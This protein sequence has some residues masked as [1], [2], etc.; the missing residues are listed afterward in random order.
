MF[1]EGG[2]MKYQNY[3]TEGYNLH[4]LK[5][6]N[7]KQIKIYVDLIT[8]EKQNFKYNIPLLASI[9]SR[10]NSKYK[11]IGDKYLASYELYAPSYKIGYQSSGTLQIFG[12]ALTF[13]NEKYTEKG[14]NEKTI[15]F[16]FNI[17]FNPKIKNDSFDEEI[18]EVIKKEDIHGMETIK[19]Q[20]R[21][22]ISRKL[23]ENMPV[24]RFPKLSLN[25]TI[26][27]EK[28]VTGKSLYKFYKNF[29]KN[30]RLEIFVTGDID[31]NQIKDIIQ[32]QITYKP[33]L[34][35]LPSPYITQ[36]KVEPLKIIKE[37]ISDKQSML[38]IGL[39]AQNLSFFESNYVLRMYSSIL[40]GDSS[41]LL[42]KEVREEKSLC[43]SITTGRDDFTGIIRISSAFDKNNY[44]EIMS[45]VKNKMEDMK[46]GNF[47]DT[48]I[49]DFK[50]SY[51]TSFDD[52]EDFI[53][54]CTNDMEGEI[55]Y[56][57]DS[58]KDKIKKIKKVTKED[59][60]NLAKKV[61]M[62]AIVFLEG[63]GQND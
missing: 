36:N 54:T 44:D 53:T 47:S 32:K 42:N 29:L 24:T 35:K 59:I 19:E 37:K 63:E 15:E 4:I 61:Y 57:D 39:V 48:Y 9:L 55:I 25:E 11:T 41:S 2:F 10:T 6:K 33:V 43:Y 56:G 20:R 38:A 62:R 3:E 31:E 7:F 40:G 49:D 34:N 45:V 5:T 30:S 12:L 16:A 22:Y 46:N 17:L 13:L 1:N 51:I 28:E 52:T 27:K 14:M 21:S 50:R 60:M 18:L 8:E 23:F 58:N 26:E